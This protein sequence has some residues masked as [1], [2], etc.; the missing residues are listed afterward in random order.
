MTALL[1]VDGL[2]KRYERFALKNVGFEVKAG[3]IVGLVG[4]N[5][6]GKTTALKCLLHFLE[7]DAG[8]VQVLGQDFFA[9]ETALKQRV[10]AVLGGAEFYPL[11]RLRTIAA[12]TRRFYGCWD[13]AAYQRCLA[14]FELDESKRFQELSSGMKVKYLLTLAL[15]HQARLFVLDEPTSGLDPVSRAEL[16]ELFRALAKSGAGILFSTHITSDLDRAADDIVYLR[17]GQVVKSAPKEEFCRAFSK[18]GSALSLEEILL[19]AERK[20]AP[21]ELPV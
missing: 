17:R 19:R 18:G 11:K 16:L 7:P 4:K 20:E 12:V 10:G 21:L 8:R 9:N 2:C 15:S 3:R 14:R 5:G 6:A 13:E 1:Q